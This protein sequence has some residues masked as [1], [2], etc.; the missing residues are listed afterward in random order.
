MP[1]VKGVIIFAILKYK[2]NFYVNKTKNYTLFFYLL[3]IPF[4]FN[5]K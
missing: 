5:N 3:S 1:K 2:F 4:T